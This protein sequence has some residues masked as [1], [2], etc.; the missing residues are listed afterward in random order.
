MTKE[1]R[2]KKKWN[3][4]NYRL[5]HASMLT[6]SRRS[7]V[8]LLHFSIC[9]C[10]PCA[11]AVPRRSK[12]IMLIFSVSFQF[13]EGYTIKTA[14]WGISQSRVFKTPDACLISDTGVTPVKNLLAMGLPLSSDPRQRPGSIP[15]IGVRQRGIYPSKKRGLP[16][17]G[18][19]KSGAAP[20]PSKR[21]R[22]SRDELVTQEAT[23]RA[24]RW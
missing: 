4:R 12:V 10:H 5:F 3:V 11:G 1:A 8:C 19:S 23:T 18:P 21:K 15:L 7:N 2:S 6:H 16:Q 24:T 17:W 13:C 14:C 9:A 20:A 22:T